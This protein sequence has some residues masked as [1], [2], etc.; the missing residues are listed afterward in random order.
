MESRLATLKS[1][2]RERAA[3]EDLLASRHPWAPFVINWFVA[4]LMVVFLVASLVWG[5]NIRTENKAREMAETALASFQAEQQAAADAK[6]LELEQARLSEEYVQKQEAQAVARAIYG[7]RNFVEKYGY[8]NA[9]LETYVR[10]MLNRADATGQS[11]IE[12]VSKKGQFLGYSDDNP[13]VQEYYD[14]A[15]RLVADW[16]AETVKP[17]DS[18]YQFAELTPEGVFLKT[19]INADGFSRRWRA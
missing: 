12:V 5:L 10:C 7:I 6:E 1:V 19:D 14:L 4:G 11:V 2:L 8:S 16:H 3:Q 17:C 18:S 15:L 13:L 9:D